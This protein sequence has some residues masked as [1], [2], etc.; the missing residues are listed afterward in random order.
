M[1]ISKLPSIVCNLV[2]TVCLLC[3]GLTAY[4]QTGNIVFE[5]EHVK[6]I[7]VPEGA[8]IVTGMKAVE[9]DATDSRHTG[10]WTLDGRRLR[11]AAT[12]TGLPSGIYL[13]TGR[14]V[15]VK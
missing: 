1:I 10:V 14:K 8:D 13:L 4:A 11:S 7:C 2:A 3:C 6:A 5:D 15:V 12:L 9:S